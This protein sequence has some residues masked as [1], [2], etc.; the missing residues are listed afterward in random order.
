MG[1]ENPYLEQTDAP[2][3]TTAFTIRFTQDGKV[4]SELQV[5]PST[6]PQKGDGRLG[7]L[8]RYA[9]Q[10]HVEIEHTCGGVCGCSTC[11]VIVTKGFDSCNE[12]TEDEEDMLDNA[13]G[14][15]E[16]SRL[17]CQCVP[18]GTSDLEVE[19]PSWNRN[20]VKETPH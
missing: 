11:H 14:L 18:D 6:I 10:E 5:D 15:T 17:S 1:G 2:L 19:V 4:L 12:S 13:P 7:S 9:Q 20:A 16:H 3:P 8:L